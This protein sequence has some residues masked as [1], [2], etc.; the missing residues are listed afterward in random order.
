MNERATVLA[1]DDTPEVLAFLVRVLTL[2]GYEVRAAASGELALAAIDANPPDLILLDVRMPGL[3]GL[4]VCRRLKAVGET[5]EIPVIL[6]SAFADVQE[7]VQGL[8][9]GAAD[10]ITKP[11]QREELLARVKTHLGLRSARASLVQQSTA[12]RRINE[13]LQ[14]EM[15]ERLHVESELR[16]S[17]AE[18]ERARCALLSVLEDRQQAEEELRQSETRYR[19]LFEAS[20]DAI[21]TLEPPTWNF[22]SANPATL[23]MFR[24]ESYVEFLACRPDDIAPEL[25]RD[26][27]KSAV[28]AERNISSAMQDGSAYFE[29]THRRLNGE[30][31]PAT[32][33]LTRIAWGGKSFLQATVRDIS[34]Q[35]RLE[36]ELGHAR[37]LEAVGQLAAGIAHE[38][39]T[40]A[41]FVGDGLQFLKEAIGGYRRSLAQYM[42]AAETLEL[43]GGHD[44]LLGDIRQTAQEIDL[45]YFEGN[46]ADA[47]E[48]C[49]DGVGR[50]ASIVRAMK[51]FAHPDQRE[52]AAADLNQALQN[53]LIIARNEYKYV[54]DVDTDYGELPPVLC[55]VGDLN[56]VFLN[57]IVNAAHA[58]R[59]VVGSSGQKGQIRVRTRREERW[60]CIQIADS[61]SGIPEAI[62]QRVFEPFFTTKEVGKGSGQGLAI[63]HSIIVTKHH[64]KLSFVSEVG[65]GTTFTIRLPTDGKGLA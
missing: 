56:Q 1:V 42:R 38:I 50:I 47:V 32:V 12:L 22:T 20:Y 11:F 7:C 28:A 21:M 14:A 5:Q 23:A 31:F 53:T 55:H 58:I 19:S 25:Q 26:G 33:G 59:D 35:K 49:I 3:D 29:W 2:G 44:A 15:A 13:Q 57:L 4:E 65:G 6:V 34:E 63:A 30:E 27:T 60:A 41:Q 62:R 17:L 54:A 9:L 52:M 46:A 8:R 37:K 64:G 40:P 10:C 45:E 51:E 24:A 18:A 43:L 39:N 61:G 16:E 36:A 48:S